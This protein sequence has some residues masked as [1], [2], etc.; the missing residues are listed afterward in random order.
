MERNINLKSVF[1][2]MAILTAFTL[3]GGSYETDTFK[4]KNNHE[5]AITFIKH[6][7]LALT[8]NN[9]SIQVDPVS[10]YAD[11]ST[12]PKAD[13]ILITHEHDDHFD[14]KAIQTLSKENTL[15]IMNEASAKKLGNPKAEIMKNGDKI[16][17]SDQI[18]IEAVPA[19]NTTPG[20]EQFHPR[21]RDNG[22]ILTIDG[23]RIYIAGDT[24]DIPEMKNLKN[25]DIAFLPVNQPYTMTVTQAVNAANMFLPKILYPYHFGNTNVKQL[26]EAL[27]NSGIEVRLRKM[28]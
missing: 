8:F 17:V 12:F 16:K 7:S 20:R 24:E 22:Y 28:E 6:G 14:P 13:I 21:H 5:V 2:M 4:T 10:M 3:K 18:L 1:M 11:Y 23:L 25:I 19:Y 26:K 15:L 9:L 27:K